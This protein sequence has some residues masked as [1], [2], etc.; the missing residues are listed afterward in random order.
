[1]CS[2]LHTAVQAVHL[3]SLPA[4]LLQALTLPTQEW[5]SLVQRFIFCV[6][7]KA[8]VEVATTTAKPRT[9]AGLP[10][11]SIGS[12]GLGRS[13]TRLVSSLGPLWRDFNLSLS[14]AAQELPRSEV[15]PKSFIHTKHNNLTL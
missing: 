14:A 10:K 15:L 4:S 1:M 13:S 5:G 11:S 3:H 6:S 7:L 2:V 12:G 8:S 9:L